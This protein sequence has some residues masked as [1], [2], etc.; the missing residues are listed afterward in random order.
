MNQPK[1]L[2]LPE[3]DE[4]GFHMSDILEYIRAGVSAI[5]ED[6]V[7][8]NFV[9]EVPPCW[10]L[11]TRT[12]TRDYE[13]VSCRLTLLWMSGF[14]IRYLFLLPTRMMVLLTGMLILLACTVVVGA[15]PEGP[16][17]RK[18]NGRL[19]I[20]CFDFVAGS[21]S[22][23]ATFH[24]TE[25]RPKSGITVANHTSPI[26]SMILSTDNVYDMVGQRHGGLLGYFMTLLSR[27]STHIWF[28]RSS[29]KDRS[30]V[31]RR[32]KEHTANPELPPILIFPEGVCVNNTSVVQF[33]KGAF[34]IDSVI[35]PVAIRFDSRF[36]D[37]YWWQDA[38]FSYVL[39][40][41]TSWAIVC[42]V[43]YL[44]PVTRQPHE[45]AIDFA[46]RVKAAIAV[47]GGLSDVSIDGFLKANPP[48]ADL[49]SQYQREF[50]KHCMPDTSD[51]FI[52]QNSS[53]D[54]KAAM[55]A[56]ARNITERSSLSRRV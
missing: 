24:N 15:F 27:S 39:Y 50:A 52:T 38:F 12:N 26:D 5:V 45:T 31:S 14:L 53:S 56:F 33:K 8:T 6:T 18:L 10:N 1:Y 44:P 25:N 17:K 22:L 7:L 13:F 9:P 16:T 40:T 32:L 55:D 36:G 49:K 21:L 3:A 48:K 43:W 51:C 30:E 19:S 20:F 23:F 34:E 37:A 28:E 54:H 47:K 2:G 41:M 42:D 46:N 35:Y 4:N 11:L 29:A